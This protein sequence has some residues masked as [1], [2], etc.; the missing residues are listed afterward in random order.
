LFLAAL[1]TRSY[2]VAMRRL[3]ISFLSLPLVA[4]CYRYAP[5]ESANIQPGTSVRARITAP[6]AE[7]LALLLGGPSGRVVSGRLVGA[8]GDT[9]VVEIPSVMQA[10]MGGSVE[11]LHQRVSFAR[12]EVVELE[13][14]R[15]DRLRTAATA[16]AVA[17]IVGAVVLGA[18]DSDRGSDGPPGDGGGN[19]TRLPVLRVRF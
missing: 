9:M 13:T 7:R 4:A 1:V 17:L 19:D 6:A 18:L 16:G 3:A 5:I 11:T 14:R 12:A 2:Y 15:L 10:S 8:Y